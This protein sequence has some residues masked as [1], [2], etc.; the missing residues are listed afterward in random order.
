MTERISNI[1]KLLKEALIKNGA[2]GN[3]DHITN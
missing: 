2:K 3:W 1:R